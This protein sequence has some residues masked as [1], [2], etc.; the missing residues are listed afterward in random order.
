VKETFTI[1][2]DNWIKK[3]PHKRLVKKRQQRTGNL[4][5]IKQRTS[6]EGETFTISEE[7][8]TNKELWTVVKTLFYILIDYLITL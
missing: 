1:S 5:L 2:E 4:N 7:T 3:I 8:C 6:S